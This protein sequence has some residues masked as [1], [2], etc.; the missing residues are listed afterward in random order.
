MTKKK[1]PRKLDLPDYELVNVRK[2]ALDRVIADYRGNANIITGPNLIEVLTEAR[3]IEDFIING[4][5]PEAVSDE[6][7]DSDTP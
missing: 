7:V 3:K 4:T 5:I 2:E 1:N 6:K